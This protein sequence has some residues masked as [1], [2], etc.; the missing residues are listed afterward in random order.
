[1]DAFQVP[2]G[3]QGV[4]ML[5]IGD[6]VLVG[7]HEIPEKLPGLVEQHLAAGG[8]DYPDIPGLKE[9]PEPVLEAT[10]GPPRSVLHLYFFY[11][12]RCGECVVV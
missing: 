1:M 5:F 4:P 11:N 6:T 10:A 9:T 3:S 2:P 8:V 7:S 12:R